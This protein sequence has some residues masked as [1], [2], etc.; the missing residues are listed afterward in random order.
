MSLEFAYALLS[1]LGA[2]LAI[3]LAL[4]TPIRRLRI[5]P[6]LRSLVLIAAVTAIAM[7]PVAGAPLS[8]WVRGAVGD[9]SVLTWILILD[10][11]AGRFGE[12]SFLRPDSRARLITGI[13]VVGLVFY[14]L[15]LGVSSFDPYGWGYAP[16]V[17]GTA[18]LALSLAAWSAGERTLAVLLLL[19]LLAWRLHLLESDNLWDYLI[20]PLLVLYACGS[21]LALV[22]CFANRGT[23]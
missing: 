9:L 2:P 13:A 12:H 10:A 17:P 15:A 8:H 16:F 7:V 1:P 22:V 3:A 5:A 21:L 18:L 11:L 20:D 4:S 19:P 23:K 6:G 14:P